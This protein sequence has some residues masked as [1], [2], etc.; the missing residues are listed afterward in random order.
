MLNTGCCHR[1]RC[2]VAS[3][4]LPEGEDSFQRH[5]ER[6]SAVTLLSELEME[7]SNKELV[8]PRSILFHII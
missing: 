5:Q 8:T 7:I 2:P 3:E 1:A 4:T 6:V